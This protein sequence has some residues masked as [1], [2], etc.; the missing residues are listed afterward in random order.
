MEILKADDQLAKR[1]PLVGGHCP[2]ISHNGEQLIGTIYRLRQSVTVSEVGSHLER[3]YL[4]VR[5]LGQR[6]QLP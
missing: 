2:A 1:R 4:H 3:V 6:G 5:L